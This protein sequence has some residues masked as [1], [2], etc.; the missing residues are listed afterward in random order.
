[1]VFLGPRDMLVLQ[2]ADGR[3]RRVING[4]LQPGLVL[5]VAVD[6]NSERG[7]LG[8]AL[9]P[10]FPTTPFVYLYFTQSATSSDTSGSP[11]A[12]RIFR[13]TWDGSVLLSPV[14]ILD[15]GSGDRDKRIVEGPSLSD[16]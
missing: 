4:V 14:L 10:N 8:I 12:N 13:Y 5:D 7:V 3:V 1:M 15:L 6:N 9:H 2:K 16:L 11:L